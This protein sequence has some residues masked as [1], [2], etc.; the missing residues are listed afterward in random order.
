MLPS[1]KAN[2]IKLWMLTTLIALA[3]LV[4]GAWTMISRARIFANKALVC[5][6]KI[7]QNSRDEQYWLL[8]V[9]E[10]ERN[11]T[12]QQASADQLERIIEAVNISAQALPPF[13]GLSSVRQHRR[14]QNARLLQGSRE[15][16]K[17]HKEAAERYRVLAEQARKSGNY[18][19][20]LMHEYKRASRRPW[21][22]EP[23][24]LVPPP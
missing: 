23:K 12:E 8:R 6:Q 7:M 13:D 24:G 11:A 5:K 18:H 3:A 10:E 15:I 19:R 2:P 22:I 4:L 16:A 14:V 9:T 20:M 17:L 21:L 1:M